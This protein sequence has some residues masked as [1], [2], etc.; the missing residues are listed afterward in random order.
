MRK[1]YVMFFAAVL[2]L[3]V[4]FSLTACGES[5]IPH[6][7][8]GGVSEEAESDGG[9]QPG[10][11]IEKPQGESYRVASIEPLEEDA[12]GLELIL[13]ADGSFSL[14][15]AET[16]SGES[17]GV[18]G[19]TGTV[20]RYDITSG[21]YIGAGDTVTLDAKKE[22]FRYVADSEASK[23]YILDKMKN[24]LGESDY[25]MLVE[26]FGKNGVENN[27]S[28]QIGTELDILLSNGVAYIKT[29]VRS[30]VRTEY[31]YDEDG[32]CISRT[33]SQT[34]GDVHA[35][36][37]KYENGKLV[38]TSVLETSADGKRKNYSER[39]FKDGASSV[40][41]YIRTETVGDDG[42][43]NEEMFCDEEGRIAMSVVSKPDGSKTEIFYDENGET[44]RRVLTDPDGSVK[45]VTYSADGSRVVELHY[46]ESGITRRCEFGHDGKLLHVG[47]S[48]SDGKDISDSVTYVGTD[49]SGIALDL[50]RDA[51]YGEGVTVDVPANE[52][53]TSGTVSLVWDSEN[54]CAYVYADI[55]DAT[56][57]FRAVYD[58]YVYDEMLWI[59]IG[60][61]DS[62]YLTFYTDRHDD[63]SRNGKFVKAE[64]PDGSG[65]KVEGVIYYDSSLG[66]IGP[67]S[68][69]F[70]TL[71]A[72]FYFVD[73]Y[74][75]ND[76]PLSGLSDEY[77]KSVGFDRSK[78]EFG[79]AQNVGSIIVDTN[80]REAE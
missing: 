2:A 57:S 53:G 35:E 8:I 75:Y 16:R 71:Y 18:S 19:F 69:G 55:N 79:F 41:T 34:G 22:F 67:D 58:Y 68:E 21:S 20:T 56:D 40:L 74:Y 6:S 12:Y 31:E 39:V 43:Y 50:V 1:L 78:I 65:W 37:Y 60:E 46:P 33:V 23:E 4:S 27:N 59:E 63:Y 11:E 72:G 66:E 32:R 80:Y 17:V 9:Q 45:D 52:N 51:A 28:D 64:K 49:C 44:T 13:G 77:L 10:T 14:I 47:Y 26:S 3:A 5:G 42:T 30:S 15:A 38:H 54:A 62:E 7:L 48:D 73:E 76:E 70:V 61:N 25:A 29:D 24:Q 36:R